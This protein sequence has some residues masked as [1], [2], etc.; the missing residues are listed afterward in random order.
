MKSHLMPS[1]KKIFAAWR[2]LR[3][4]KD[5]HLVWVLY[6]AGLLKSAEHFVADGGSFYLKDGQVIAKWR[7]LACPIS[8]KNHSVSVTLLES[9]FEIEQ[10][11]I[12]VSNNEGFLEVTLPDGSFLKFNDLEVFLV[13]W[14]VGL[15]YGGVDVCDR[16]VVDIGAHRGDSPIYFASRGANRIIAFEPIRVFYREALENITLNGMNE[17]VFL[18][19]EGIGNA[20]I[21]YETDRRDGEKGSLECTSLISFDEFLVRV[22]SL[23]IGEQTWVLKMDCEGCEYDLLMPKGNLEKLAAQHVG[24]IIIE[25]HDSKRL[26]ALTKRFTDACFQITQIVPKTAEIGILRADLSEL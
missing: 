17:R 8:T 7:S 25:Y 18:F 26:Q 15:D 11:G 9:I 24:T 14:E 2:I 10:S 19:N 21:G 20:V 22:S 3:Q 23:V 6:R 1:G 12:L 4:E 16:T 5:L 13:F